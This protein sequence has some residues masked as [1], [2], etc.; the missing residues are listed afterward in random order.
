MGR[1]LAM[2]DLDRILL[3]ISIAIFIVVLIIKLI[4]GNPITREYDSLKIKKNIEK[5]V[6]EIESIETKN[7]E[8]NNKIQEENRA[9][10][11]PFVEFIE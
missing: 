8:M 9:S 10:Y 2:K 6:N 1:K 11:P 3:I 7:M 5:S 4:P